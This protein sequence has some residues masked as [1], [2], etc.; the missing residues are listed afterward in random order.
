[1]ENA[2]RILE[3]RFLPDVVLL[4]V[5]AAMLGAALV[6]P[7]FYL[8]FA[9]RATAGVI[10]AAVGLG[11]VQ[12]AGV[13]FRRARTTVD[14]MRPTST[15]SLIISGAYRLSR[16]P[17]YFGMTLVLLGWA[18]FL[19]NV[20]AFALIAVFVAYINRFQ[21]I[22]EERALSALFGAEYASY[23]AKVRRWL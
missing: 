7:S 16:N 19:S 12:A 8:P 17:V 1:M 6:F 13:S 15:S 20:L 11:V 4:V 10:L 23:R 2:V 22:P 14:P 9:I 18:I 5:A 21:I 3:L